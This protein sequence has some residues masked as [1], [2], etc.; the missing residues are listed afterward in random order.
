MTQTRHPGFIPSVLARHAEEAAFLWLLRDRA[1]RSPQYNLRSL[2][3]LDQRVEAHLD[4]LRVAGEHGWAR[5]CS[6]FE[7]RQEPGE[8]FAAAVLA[9][10]STDPSRIH[11]VLAASTS[12]KSARALVSA[13]GWLT[14]DAASIVLPI[15]TSSH[16][17]FTRRIGIAGSAA[18]SVKPGWP[19]MESCLRD[20]DPI[21]LTCAV[22][23]VGKLGYTE[24]LP[25]VRKN[26]TASDLHVRFT[27]AWTTARLSSDASA[28][29]E[30]QSI[31]LTEPRYRRQAA[32]MAVR[33]LDAA[34]AQRWIEMLSNTP[35]CKR[36]SIQAAGAYGDPAA[37]PRLHEFMT[38]PALA[39]LA[40]EAFSAITGARLADSKL[41][42]NQPE[43]FESGPTDDPDDPDVE[44]D[45]YSCLD[46]PATEKV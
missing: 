29:G 20:T 21:T 24:G 8:T 38:V 39:R 37:V 14:D 32:T 41:E 26:L 5:M 13:V 27:V 17:S 12:P 42:A 9:F 45:P 1:V 2:S 19:L 11:Q 44:L 18:R 10:E 40:G 7:S 25:L 36:A 34:S 22:K 30:L 33:K 31:A 15:L 28:V 3:E 43:G 46:W 35:G 6:E 16:D 4:G 23:A